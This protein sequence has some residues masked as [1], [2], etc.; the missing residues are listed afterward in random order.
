MKKELLRCPWISQARRAVRVLKAM[1]SL[2]VGFALGLEFGLEAS[3][4][5][6][7]EGL[8]SPRSAQN[9]RVGP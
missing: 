1:S 6:L 9:L 4:F 7:F 2:S 5:P 8:E 3:G